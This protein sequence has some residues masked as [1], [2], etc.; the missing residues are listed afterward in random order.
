MKTIK[1]TEKEE[2]YLNQLEH[3]Q[4][5]MLKRISDEKR[6]LSSNS[7]LEYK[8]GNIQYR[9][10]LTIFIKEVISENQGICNWS[11]YQLWDNRNREY[12]SC[13]DES[14]L[15]IP[16]LRKVLR[17]KTECCTNNTSGYYSDYNRSIRKVRSYYKH[18]TEKHN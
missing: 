1:M 11:W 18:Q 15:D 6:R 9:E 5:V 13:R 4:S 10:V 3:K 12:N 17:I 14:L 7:Y 16:V 8:G 2:Q